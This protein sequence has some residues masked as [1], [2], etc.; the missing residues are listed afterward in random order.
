[1]RVKVTGQHQLERYFVG[2]WSQTKPNAGFDSESEKLAAGV[3]HYGPDFVKLLV[4]GYKVAEWAEA[5]IRFRGDGPPVIEVVGDSPGW[6][7]LEVAEASRK[8]V[9]TIGL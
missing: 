1:M 6:V 3:I 7:V 4:V 5:V 2:A 8:S 9:S